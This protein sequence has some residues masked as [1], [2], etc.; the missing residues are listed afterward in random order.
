M[1]T[2][3]D[4]PSSSCPPLPCPF[5]KLTYDVFLSFR[6]PDTCT[7]FTDYLYAALKHKGIIYTFRDD[8]ELNKGELIGPNL[9]EAIEESIVVFSH[10]YADSS[11]C[12]DE[13]AKVAECRKAM[14]QT[15]RPVFYHVDPSDV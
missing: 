11:W 13:F 2:K 3:I 4:I 5:S 9:L 6:G 15:F 8:E 10:N 7:N 12:L 1:T 14:G